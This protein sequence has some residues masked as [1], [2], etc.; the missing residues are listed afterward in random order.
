MADRDFYKM[1]GVARTASETEIRKAYRELARKHHPDRNPG[2]KAAEDRFKDISQ[3]SDVLL[4]KKKRDLYDEFGEVG[5]KDGFNPDTYRQYRNAQNRSSSGGQGPNLEDLFGARGASW[6]GGFGGFEDF[7]GAG[8]VEDILRGARRRRHNPASPPKAE[9]FSELTLSFLDALRGG[10][11]ALSLSMPS[12]ESRELRVRIPAG[13]KDGGQIRLREQGVEGGDLIVK[14]HVEE[15]PLLKRDEDDLLLNLPITVGEAYRGAKVAV[16]TLEGEVSLAVP[17]RAKS[18]TKLRLR[19]KGV[20]SGHKVGDLIVTLLIRVPDA[21][22]E[23]IEK[24]V[25]AL[26]QKYGEDVRASIK[27]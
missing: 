13:V 26:D 16:P 8:S 21:D 4:H 12:G 10:E 17:K 2:N 14:I 9:L 3:A 20:K 15:H 6:P 22:D 5:L 19:G 1:L 25:T 23:E 7:R 11:R 27:L 24:L 18:G